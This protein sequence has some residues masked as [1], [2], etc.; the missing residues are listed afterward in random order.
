MIDR[1]S[2]M[3]ELRVDALNELSAL[4]RESESYR[5]TNHSRFLNRMINRARS[6][7]DQKRLYASY[8]REATHRIVVLPL[9]G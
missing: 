6:Y 4:K 1:M 3:R 9:P 8:V 5:K 7:D 2:L